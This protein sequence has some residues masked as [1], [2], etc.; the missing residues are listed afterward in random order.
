MGFEK[1]SKSFLLAVHSNEFNK[2]DWQQAKKDVDK[3]AKNWGH[4]LNGLIDKIEKFEKSKKLNNIK[5]W[6]S[7]VACWESSVEALEAAYIECR[8]PTVRRYHEGFHYCSTL[9]K[10]K[11]YYDPITSLNF[12]G[13][14]ARFAG[15]IHRCLKEIFNIEII[16]DEYSGIIKN[17]VG[18]RFNNLYKNYWRFP[19]PKPT[20]IKGRIWLVD[21]DN[22]DTDM[23]FHNKHL[24]ITKLEEMGPFTFGNLKGW[25]DFPQKVQPGDVLMVGQN[26]GSGSSRQQ[27]VDC[28]QALGVPVIVGESF[29]AIYKRNAINAGMALLECPGLSDSGLSS[30]DEVEVN[31][32]TGE[33]KCSAKGITLQGKPFSSVQMD[34][35]QAGGLFEYGRTS[36]SQ[37]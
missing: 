20:Q 28:F 34:I 13:F 18:L 27:A 11:I 25:T 21:Q 26:F 1:I 37:R 15:L 16:E 35:Y 36:A 5:V 3:L 10:K 8:Y 12:T 7:D 19:M 30:G 6:K 17:E 33:V 32:E 22:I 31:L 29:G 2:Q 9:D 4:K 23:I 14:C 24:H